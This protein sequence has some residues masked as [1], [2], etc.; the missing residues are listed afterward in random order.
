MKSITKFLAFI[1]YA[2]AIFFMPNN[3]VVFAVLIINLIIM[4]WAK[5]NFIKTV[6]NLLKFVPFVLF[7]V[8]I[9]YLLGDK[10]EALWVG[11]KLLLVCNITYIY[12]KT[13]TVRDLAKAIAMLCTPLKYFKVNVQEIEILVAISISMVPTL[14]KEYSEVKEAC[15]AKGIQFNVKNMKIILQKLFLST[16]K[17]VN[18]ID[19]ALLE[20]GYDL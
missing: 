11:A 19:E 17:R 9:N 6:K 16:F 4:F 1:L 10:I 14:K 20:K 3:A 7:T 2:T 13:T 15:K 18:E 5:V 12:A 8:I